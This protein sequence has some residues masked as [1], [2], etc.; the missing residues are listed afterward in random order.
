MVFPAALRA[1]ATLATN[2]D[3]R[4]IVGVVVLIA[5][6]PFILIVVVIVAL[7]GSGAS[8]NNAVV[9]YAFNGGVIPS[10]T[11]DEYRKHLEDMRSV[12]VRLDMMITELNEGLDGIG[13]D[14]DRVKS[15]FFALH[16]GD[17]SL[18][19]D[20]DYY[21][22]YLYCFIDTKTVD[23]E[24]VSF[25]LTG[26]GAIYSNITVFLGRAMTVDEKANAESI[27]YSLINDE[28]KEHEHDS[29]IQ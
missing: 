15:I 28:R 25:A 3:A 20:D 14:S 22:N 7:L 2:K 5:L 8:H 13:I 11:P 16:F 19:Y 12:F 6:S 21:T 9:N 23:D 29:Q 17:Y 18:E 4:R 1:A 27:Y 24:T 10:E 26:T